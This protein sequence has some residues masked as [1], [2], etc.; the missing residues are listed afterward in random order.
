MKM[1]SDDLSVQRSVGN[2]ET[3]DLILRTES[4]FT[5]CATRACIQDQIWML[6]ELSC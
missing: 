6:F 1:S 2:Y 4:I 5:R 3:A